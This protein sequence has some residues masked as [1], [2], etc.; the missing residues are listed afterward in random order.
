MEEIMKFKYKKAILFIFIS[1]LCI[2]IITLSIMPNKH[3]KESMNYKKDNTTSDIITGIADITVTPTA[4]VTIKPTISPTPTPL[5]VYNLEEDAYPEITKLI[6]S[7][8]KAKLNYDVKSL[9]KLLSDPSD[10]GTKKELKEKVQYFEKYSNIKCYVKKSYEEGSYIVYVYNEVKFIN[11]KTPA[12][13][14]Y[15]FY[16]I[17]DTN[18]T[19][20]IFS[21]AYDDTTSEYY[22]D[23]KNDSDVQE[24]ID[25]TNK[26]ADKAKKKDKNLK[27]FWDNLIKA[28]TSS[29]A[30]VEE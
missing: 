15:Q 11:I 8:Y 6:K 28:Q 2:G 1:T 4:Q 30:A 20:K 21:G 23:R 7:Y 17:T 19:L 27:S 13:A 9:K 25:E 3:V 16:L 5:P 10:V 18:G 24:L 26:K 22:Y 12:P 14:V 29:E